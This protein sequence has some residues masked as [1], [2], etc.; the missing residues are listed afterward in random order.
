MLCLVRSCAAGRFFV[1][2]YT[3]PVGS[4]A[5]ETLQELYSECNSLKDRLESVVASLKLGKNNNNFLQTK[6]Y[7]LESVQSIVSQCDLLFEIQKGTR[8]VHW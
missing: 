8:N 6:E 3:S 7:H 5:L 2:S 4:A 1:R